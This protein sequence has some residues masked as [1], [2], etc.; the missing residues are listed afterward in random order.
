MKRKI[1][2]SFLELV[3]FLISTLFSFFRSV[4]LFFSTKNYK[5]KKNLF[6]E[7]LDFIFIIWPKD[8]FKNPSFYKLFSFFWD[9]IKFILKK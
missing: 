6:F 2:N 4:R 5:I 8:F 7:S 1:K 9:F 3:L